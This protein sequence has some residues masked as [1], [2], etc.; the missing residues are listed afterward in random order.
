MD[1]QTYLLVELYEIH[2]L[3]NEKTECTHGTEHNGVMYEE[4]GQMYQT[5][6]IRLQMIQ[7]IQYKVAHIYL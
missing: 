6:S 3:Q 7:M 1:Y 2:T 5:Y 4:Q